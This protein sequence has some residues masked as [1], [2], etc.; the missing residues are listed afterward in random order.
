MD[1]VQLLVKI[2]QCNVNVSDNVSV[3]KVAIR[4]D[5]ASGDNKGGTYMISVYQHMQPCYTQRFLLPMK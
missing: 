2:P 4:C 3:S 5:R 1:I